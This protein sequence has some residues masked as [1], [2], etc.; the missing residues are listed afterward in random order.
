MAVI[1][2]SPIEWFLEMLKKRFQQKRKNLFKCDKKFKDCSKLVQEMAN[3]TNYYKESN[4]ILHRKT[5]RV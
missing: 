4:I 3:T 1:E 5:K 2:Y